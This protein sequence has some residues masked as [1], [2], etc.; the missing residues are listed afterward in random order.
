M[1]KV[2]YKYHSFKK[3]MVLTVLVFIYSNNYA[4]CDM[5]SIYLGLHPNQVKNGINIRYRYSL[6]ESNTSHIHNGIVHSLN[7]Q[8]RLFQT[9][10]TWGQFNLGRKMQVLIMLPYVMNSVE[11]KS[12][13]LDAYNYIGD[14]QSLIRYQL[15]R[16]ES[17]K[18]FASQV[19]V[20]LGVKAPTGK[21]SIYSNEGYIDQ[22]IQT[23]SGTWDVI[24]N[25]G[26]LLKYKNISFNEEVLYK[27]N[28][29]N[30]LHY[31]F[32]NRFSSNSTIYYSFKKKEISILPSLGYL[33]ETAKQDK[34][35][36]LLVYNTNGTSQYVAYGIDVYV[37][38][39][40]FNINY[41]KPII[42]NLRDKEISNKHRFIVGLGV[43]F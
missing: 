43:N 31:K 26:Y 36:N 9:V 12:L 14:I 29:E 15:Y 16:S 27:M 3:W 11:E 37:N 19:S 34:L 38:Q 21:Y 39:I 13:V 4:G 35:S 10:E 18:Q 23:G 32:A 6:Y 25:I 33:I 20:G 8:K 1:Y 41:Q 24:Y 17:E 42:E 22:H 2:I 5:C 40:N 28:S 7:P 30:D